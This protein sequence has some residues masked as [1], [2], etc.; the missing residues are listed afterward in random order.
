[1]IIA[2]VV[3]W[4]FARNG[5]REFVATRA[6][7]AGTPEEIWDRVMFYEDVPGLPA[8]PLRMLLPAPV[9]TDGDKSRV[10]ATVR[11]TYTHGE[12]AKRI[13]AADAPRLLQFDVLDQ[14]LGIEGCLVA[15][16]GSYQIDRGADASDVV[17]T[18]NYHGYL[19]PR[20]IWRH[21]ER[22]LVGQLHSH[23]LRGIGEAALRRHPHRVEPAA[24]SR[25]R[26][27]AV[28]EV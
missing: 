11:C 28:P 25:T 4:L 13:T 15:R 10:G 9:R 23:I 26:A 3:S 8:F 14:R 2:G 22:L 19:S 21:L 27:C 1:M 6:R 7:V 20:S 24:E 17:L 18:T 12:L 5:T 16:G